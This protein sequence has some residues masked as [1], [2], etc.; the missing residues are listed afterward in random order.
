MNR[1]ITACALGT[2]M[3]LSATAWSIPMN[4][5][6]QFVTECGEVCQPDNKG[7]DGFAD[8]QLMLKDALASFGP[9]PSANVALLDGALENG[10]FQSSRWWWAGWSN[11]GGS[12]S[13]YGWSWNGLD[14]GWTLTG[15]I[16]SGD[17]TTGSVPEPAP[18]AI[19]G[20]GLV[21]LS[22]R[23]KFSR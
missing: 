6:N 4:L 11:D 5:P 2:A 9:P 21:L 10:I 7:T 15:N 22:L 16:D 14:D 18:L 23:R 19:L 8:I 3:L 17:T 1:L 20:L 12:W 13:W